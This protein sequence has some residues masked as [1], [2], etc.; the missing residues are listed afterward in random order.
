MEEAGVCSLVARVE[1]LDEVLAVVEALEEDPHP[2]LVLVY[3]V[4]VLVLV[5]VEEVQGAAKKS[6]ISVLFAQKEKSEEITSDSKTIHHSSYL[7]IN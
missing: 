2:V 6:L 3:P 7:I 1:G 5:L 4:P